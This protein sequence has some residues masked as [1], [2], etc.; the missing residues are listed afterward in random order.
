MGT[1]QLAN[2]NESLGV[3][4]DQNQSVV[5]VNFDQ[6]LVVAN[7]YQN[8]SFDQVM[9]LPSLYVLFFYIENK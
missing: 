7:Y 3:L 2:A 8:E 6:N 9:V 5:Q 1:E 4:N